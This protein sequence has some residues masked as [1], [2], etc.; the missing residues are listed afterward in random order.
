MVAKRI[1]NVPNDECKSIR[2]LLL[3]ARAKQGLFQADMVRH[4]KITPTT[5]KNWERGAIPR[6]EHFV[7]IAKFCNVPLERVVAFATAERP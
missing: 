7:P 3:Y 2:Q 5:Y 6:A 4:F 1:S